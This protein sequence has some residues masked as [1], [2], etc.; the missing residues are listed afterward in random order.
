MANANYGSNAWYR[1]KLEVGKA[2]C[3]DLL[4]EKAPQ[5]MSISFKLS[6]RCRNLIR[7]E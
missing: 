1:R 5:W 2:F 3:E 4:S 7:G 6:M